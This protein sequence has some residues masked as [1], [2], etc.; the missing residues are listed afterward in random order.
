MKPTALAGVVTY[1]AILV[2]SLFARLVKALVPCTTLCTTA[3]HQEQFTLIFFLSAD[4]IGAYTR[5][6]TV[7]AETGLECRWCQQ[8]KA[9][10]H[11]TSRLAIGNDVH[12]VS[13][14]F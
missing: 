4:H 8:M 9:S 13:Y 2:N 1:S 5:G 10:V 3:D 12:T 14:N 7:Y 11:T 6:A